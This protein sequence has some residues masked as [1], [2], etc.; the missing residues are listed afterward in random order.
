MALKAA[1]LVCFPQARAILEVLRRWR[2]QQAGCPGACVGLRPQSQPPSPARPSASR[3]LSF[4]LV[5]IMS[6]WAYHCGFKQLLCSPS[7]GWALALTSCLFLPH[8]PTLCSRLILAAVSLLWSLADGGR[9]LFLTHLW[10]N[11]QPCCACGAMSGDGMR[12]LVPEGLELSS[13]IRPEEMPWGDSTLRRRRW[14]PCFKETT[15]WRPCCCV[16]AAAE[17]GVFQTHCLLSKGRTWRGSVPLSW[18]ASG[19]GFGS[20]GLEVREKIVF[21]VRCWLLMGRNVEPQSGFPGGVLNASVNSCLKVDTWTQ[22]LQSLDSMGS[23][24]PTWT[25]VNKMVLPMIFCAVATILL[26]F[27]RMS[28]CSLSCNARAESSPHSRGQEQHWNCISRDEKRRLLR[29]CCTYTI[30]IVF[31]QELTRLQ[32]LLELHSSP[33]PPEAPP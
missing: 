24:K 29:P 25:Q 19:W 17:G 8:R 20:L 27:F 32:K 33:S 18:G 6:V 31:C 21:E 3:V 30:A 9:L 22:N 28:D 14:S 26:K 5:S 12:G 11:H 4:S 15:K 10:G 13:S 23:N 7:L 1:F 2:V 16:E